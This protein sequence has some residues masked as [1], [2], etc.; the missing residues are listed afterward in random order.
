[1][2]LLRYLLLVALVSAG[3]AASAARATA[4]V[5][6]TVKA[7]ATPQAARLTFA[8]STSVVGRIAQ[9]GRTVRLV[10]DRAAPAD[11]ADA[12]ARLGGWITGLRVAGRPNEVLIDLA[13]GARATLPSHAG[14]R[15]SLVLTR[16]AGDEAGADR[17]LPLI[18]ADAEVLG[19]QAAL[20]KDGSP[21]RR[22]RVRPDGGQPAAGEG[23]PSPRLADVAPAAGPVRPETSADAVLE[24]RWSKPVPAAILEQAGVLWL[25]FGASAKDLVEVRGARLGPVPLSGLP[26]ITGPNLHVLRFAGAGPLALPEVS[27]L[28]S[29]R[30]GTTWILEPA[31]EIAGGGNAIQ[32]HGDRLMLNAPGPTTVVTDPES[33]ETL[34]IL[35]TEDHAL[36]QARPVYTIDV[37]FLPTAAG[38]AW[39]VLTDGVKAVDVGSGVELTR[40]GG[41]RLASAASAPEAVSAASA[42]PPPPASSRYPEAGAANAPAATEREKVAGGPPREG[43][44]APLALAGLEGEGASASR[45]RELSRR[46]ADGPDPAASAAIRVELARI[47][48]ADGLGAEALAVLDGA[49]RPGGKVAGDRPDPVLLRAAAELLAGR[50]GRTLE[51]LAAA[52][53]ADDPEVALWRAAAEADLERW[54]D[55]DRSLAVAGRVWTSYPSRLSL[56]FGLAAAEIL[57][58]AGKLDGA[59]AAL[60]KLADTAAGS[61]AR[62]RLMLAKARVLAQAGRDREAGRTLGAA[63]DQGDHVTRVTTRFLAVEQALRRSETTPEEAVAALTEQRRLWRGHPEERDMLSSLA[64]LHERQG[65]LASA[66]AIWGTALARRSDDPTADGVRARMRRALAEAVGG[67]GGATDPISALLLYRTHSDLLDPPVRETLAGKLALR[68]AAAGLPQTAGELLTENA[69]G[70]Q[71]GETG[72]KLA[73]FRLDADDP[74]GALKAASD[75][76]TAGGLARAEALL[77]LGRPAEAA[78]VLEG[79]QRQ[80]AAPLRAEAAWRMGDWRGFLREAATMPISTDEATRV[81]RELRV[82]I[83]TAA[84]F[85]VAPLPEEVSGSAREHPF[86]TAVRAAT[87]SSDA[88]PT[89]VAS[90]ESALDALRAGFRALEAQG[91][92]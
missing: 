6:A 78:R 70:K 36:R 33:G 27:A 76:G 85:T 67:E 13:P 1:M 35:P 49:A 43:A 55:A 40:S 72:A 14:T 61:A 88:A 81:R 41:L 38:L 58:R 32:I 65:D 47:L 23:S 48:I 73:R 9:S 7:E 25:A 37:D 28:R 91:A 39:R 42:P 54:P 71:P 8:W 21:V 19:R 4:A 20:A 50:P 92:P 52:P 30:E 29:R 10:F 31:P 2:R 11:L 66:L 5:E 17:P 79:D 44:I 34:H 69:Q 68:L 53:G 15:L 83:A 3:L 46:L 60:D 84:A 64:A 45:R 62:G 82:A 57:S 22:P 89:T 26:S 16:A 56:R 90:L 74:S 63:G 24:V 12:R 51:L 18:A 86:T 87:P 80:V 59:L 75:A 77:A